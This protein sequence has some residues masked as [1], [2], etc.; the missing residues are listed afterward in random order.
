MNY[1]DYINVEI[2]NPDITVTESVENSPGATL[3]TLYDA[4]GRD[5]TPRDA[6]HSCTMWS[7]A[8]S[9]AAASNQINSVE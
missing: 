9:R 2:T 4:C 1:D 5:A 7:S 6:V 3:F 8:R